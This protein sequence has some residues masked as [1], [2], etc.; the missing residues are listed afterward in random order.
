[1][2]ALHWTGFEGRVTPYRP[3]NNLDYVRLQPAESATTVCMALPV[4]VVLSVISVV[5]V[6]IAIA[7]DP[8]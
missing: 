4:S 2:S 5:V 1:M 3:V 7:M 8:G 6:R